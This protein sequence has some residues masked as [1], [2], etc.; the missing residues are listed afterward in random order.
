MNMTSDAN[1]IGP[2]PGTTPETGPN[3]AGAR[4][5][6][7]RSKVL[8]G[9]FSILPGLGQAYVGHYQRGFLFAAIAGSTLAV[10]SGG[11]VKGAEPL[12][13]IF[14]TFFWFF[15]IIDAVRLA[16]FYN[17][18]MAG[19]ELPRDI[20]LPTRGGALAGGVVLIA[21]G[22]LLFLHTMFGMPL[23]WLSSWWPVAPIGFGIWLVYRAVR[24]RSAQK[25]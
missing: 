21:I 15:N 2:L 17:E 23:D 7:R 14:L 1:Q 25:Q 4:P 9:W 3:A 5:A 16:T 18:A 24:D 8:A 13:S 20:L 12:F 19:G 6:H 22:F 10:L 11:E